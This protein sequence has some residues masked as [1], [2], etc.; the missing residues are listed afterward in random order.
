[1]D[2]CHCADW[3]SHYQEVEIGIPFTGLTLLFLSQVGTCISNTICLAFFYFSD[4][5]WAVVV[6]FIN[7]G[8]IVGYHCLKFL[9]IIFNSTHITLYNSLHIKN[10]QFYTYTSI[11]HIFSSS[12]IIYSI[13]FWR[14]YLIISL[15]WIGNWKFDI[16]N[17]NFPKQII[18]TWSAIVFNMSKATILFLSWVIIKENYE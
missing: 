9:F 16:Q 14:T 15:E 10:L 4:F 12:C 2:Y 18:S 7:I 1:L 13:I 6:R 5:R 3:I 8:G 11:W 17:A